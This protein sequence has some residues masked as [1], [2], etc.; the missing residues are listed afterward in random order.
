MLEFFY[1]SLDASLDASWFYFREL[2]CYSKRVRCIR[3]KSHT[4]STSQQHKRNTQYYYN[5]Q[6]VNRSREKKVYIFEIKIKISMSVLNTETKTQT[7]TQYGWKWN[8]HQNQ[9]NHIN[10]FMWFV[11]SIRIQYWHIRLLIHRLVCVYVFVFVF[12]ST[13]CGS[14]NRREPNPICM[15]SNKMLCAGY[16]QI[17]S[18]VWLIKYSTC[19]RTNKRA[20]NQTHIRFLTQQ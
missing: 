9:H 18:S 2:F 12:A 4:S 1:A 16:S 13:Y 10:I 17:Y 8:I 6:Y 20:N 19:E 7:Q 3:R 15:I 5:T 11:T 14:E